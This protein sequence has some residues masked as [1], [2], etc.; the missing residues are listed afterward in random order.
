[1]MP[2]SVPMTGLARL[3]APADRNRRSLKAKRGVHCAPHPPNSN[4]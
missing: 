4:L 1:M 3:D 2:Q